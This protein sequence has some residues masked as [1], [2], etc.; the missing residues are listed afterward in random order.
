MDQQATAEGQPR[1]RRK[2]TDEDRA[3]AVVHVEAGEKLFA[4]GDGVAAAAEFLEAVE[5]DPRSTHAWNDL[6][7]TLHALGERPDAETAFKTAAR[8]DPNDPNVQ[9][10]LAMVTDPP[11]V[12]EPFQLATAAPVRL[13][14][15]PDYA[16]PGE[17]ASMMRR[18]GARVADNPEVCLCLRHDPQ[19]DGD[20]AAAVEA[21]QR[22][23]DEI[24]GADSSLEVLLIDDPMERDDWV[25][26]GAATHAVLVLASARA[27]PRLSF[28]EAVQRRKIRS[29][30]E[31]DGWLA[32]IAAAAPEEAAAE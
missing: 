28:N 16:A 4:S 27:Q 7:V 23:H 13:L 26:L 8:L 25:R 19:V 17:L 6:G 5:R 32:E 22:A 24:V 3:A 29:G 18:F 21:L 12:E 30:T 14:A 15:W 20:P 10:N 1:K 2:I 11:E 31:L 9:A